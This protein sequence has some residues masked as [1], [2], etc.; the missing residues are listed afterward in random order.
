MYYYM[1]IYKKLDG[2]LRFI[3]PTAD[4]TSRVPRSKSKGQAKVICLQVVWVSMQCL[5]DPL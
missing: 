3:I 2:L 4:T 5:Q 1:Y